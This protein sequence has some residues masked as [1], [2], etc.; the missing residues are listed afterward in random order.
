MQLFKTK[1]KHWVVTI[2]E[3]STALTFFE[4]P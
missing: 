2:L 3:Q 4:I 1:L